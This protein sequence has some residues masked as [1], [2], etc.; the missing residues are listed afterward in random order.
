MNYSIW[1]LHNAIK[2]FVSAPQ[3]KQTSKKI[4]AVE[5]NLSVGKPK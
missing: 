5:Q 1:P 3:L 2:I 4:S